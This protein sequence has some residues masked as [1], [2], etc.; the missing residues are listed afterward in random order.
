M[1]AP[2]LTRAAMQEAVNLLHKHV[3]ISGAARAAGLART[4]FQCRVHEAWANGISTHEAAEVVPDAKD[5]IIANLRG[6]IANMREQ[7]A[8]ASKPHFTIRQ[9]V[10]GSSSKIRV[11]CIGD[12][13][14]SPAIPDKSRFER[15]GKYIKEQKPDVVIQIGDFATLD[16]LNTHVPNETYAG[17]AKPTFIAD[18]VSFNQALDAMQ[19]DGVERH[20]TLGNH[21]RRLFAF[22][23]RAPEAYGMMQHELQSIFERHGWTY[24][25]YGMIHYLGGVGFAH[26]AL[27]R[28]GKSVGGKN[29]ENTVA[30]ELVHD[31]V[32]GH[33][34]IERTTRYSKIGPSNYV[35]SCNVGC[36][37]PDGHVEDYAEHAMSGGWSWGIMELTIQRGHI[38]D[39]S[40]VPMTRLEELYGKTS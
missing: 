2:R 14:D 4:T 25:P 3:T 9:E 22:E 38:Q 11:V 16:S 31:L 8:K 10:N 12:A 39:R 5:Q 1:P 36:A 6:E 28:L 17:K 18:M 40:W 37:L 21:E 35:I 27:N 15:I 7:S 30:N 26:C 34:H 23:D 29:A 19:L 13:H 33:S 20:C 24:S 32:F